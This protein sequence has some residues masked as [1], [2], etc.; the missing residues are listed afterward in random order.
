MNSISD[1]L[2]IEKLLLLPEAYRAINAIEHLVPSEPGIYCIQTINAEAFLKIFLNTFKVRCHKIVYFGITKGS[3]K[4]RLLEQEL[5]SKGPGT[6]FRSIGAI[7][8]FVPPAGSLSTYSNKNNFKFSPED[9]NAIINWMNNNL[10]INWV[11]VDSN[12][13]A[14]E[15]QLIVKYRPLL[16][17]RDN[18]EVI[19]E[20]TMLRAK[21]KTIANS[22]AT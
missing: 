21:C 14:I 8:G 6:F 15:K 13:R 4:K 19:E 11:L 17:I 18:P 12:W 5:H 1:P 9:I 10:I 22:P 20:V 7:L 3:L 16:N 2:E